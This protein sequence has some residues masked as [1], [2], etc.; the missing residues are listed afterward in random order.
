MDNTSDN[1][2]ENGN[3]KRDN[4]MLLGMSFGM[5]AGS[6]GMSILS[7]FGQIALGGYCIGIGMLLGMLIGMAIPKK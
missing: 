3:N 4:Y 6:V 5:M 2:R 1:N 7:M